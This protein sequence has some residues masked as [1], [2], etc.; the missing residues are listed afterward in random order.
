[1]HQK[2]YPLDNNV[3]F[4]QCDHASE[5]EVGFNPIQGA[6]DVRLIIK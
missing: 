1:L 4:C 6:L 5:A 3:P 2:L